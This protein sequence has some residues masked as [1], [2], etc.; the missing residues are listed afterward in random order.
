VRTDGKH[1]ISLHPLQGSGHTE[2]LL[3]AYL[4][5]EKILI[6]ADAYNPAPQPNAP[7]V[8]PASPYT[9]NLVENL[10]RLKLEVERIIPI[11]YPADG[12]TVTKAELMRAVGRQST[13]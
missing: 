13:N 5:K 2:G 3:V 10:N 7:V 9:L 8:T 1:A 6:E 4:Q 11:H 12:R